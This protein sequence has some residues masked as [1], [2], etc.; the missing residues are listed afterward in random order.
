M[1]LQELKM[2]YATNSIPLVELCVYNFSRQ[3]RMLLVQQ[4]IVILN[5]WAAK[6]TWISRR[7]V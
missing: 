1:K 6:A 4:N 2:Q 5:Y 7:I 3:L